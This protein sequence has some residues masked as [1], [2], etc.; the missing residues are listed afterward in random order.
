M[1]S[2]FIVDG[3]ISE[4]VRGFLRDNFLYRESV[5]GLA[6]DES[7]SGAGVLDSVGVLSLIVF[8]EE[9]F[10]VSVAD[11]EVTPEN[12][13]SIDSL[14]AFIRRKLAAAEA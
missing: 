7:L 9:A 10:G 12:L 11:D 3:E 8:L 1:T 5:E 4:K 2:R 6:G 13:D 14:T